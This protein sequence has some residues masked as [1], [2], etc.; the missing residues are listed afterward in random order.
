MMKNAIEYLNINDRIWPFLGGISALFAVTYFAT[1]SS[2]RLTISDQ[3]HITSSA[4]RSYGEFIKEASDDREMIWEILSNN[5]S[6]YSAYENRIQTILDTH[7]KK[8]IQSR[9]IHFF[10]N[11]VKTIRGSGNARYDAL[12]AA[13]QELAKTY[14]MAEF[15]RWTDKTDVYRI[16]HAMAEQAHTNYLAHHNKL[17]DVAT[18]L[19]AESGI[20]IQRARDLSVISDEKT[21]KLR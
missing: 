14:P 13:Y 19:L 16:T 11:D 9:G 5:A 20:L 1:L 15:E 10:Q 21:N 17:L 3:T 2:K 12:F 7:K 8:H 4:L 18:E 6:E